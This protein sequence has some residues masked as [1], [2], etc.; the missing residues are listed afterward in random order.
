[1]HFSLDPSDTIKWHSR[2]LCCEHVSPP[3]SN[4]MV[5]NV[6]KN[7][8]NLHYMDKLFFCHIC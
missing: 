3:L 5:I 6:I 1:M 8:C 2:R 7:V 4:E